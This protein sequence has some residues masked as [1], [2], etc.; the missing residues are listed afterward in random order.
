MNQ[1]FRKVSP[2]LIIV[3]LLKTICRKPSG[4]SIKRKKFCSL[5]KQVVINKSLA[6][7]NTSHN[8]FAKK[9]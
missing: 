4:I 3:I 8:H 9:N 6:F 1:D 5:C 7:H 2:S